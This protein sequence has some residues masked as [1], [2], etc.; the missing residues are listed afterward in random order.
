MF[1]KRLE[2]Q[3]FKSFPEKVK[4][5]FKEGVTAVVGPN[6]SG[7]SNISDAIRWVLGEQSAKSLRGDK[8]ED[9]IFTGTKNRKPLGFSEV[10]IT[11]DNLDKKLNLEF[12]EITVTRKVYRSGESGYY[13]NGAACRLKDIHELFMDTGIGKEGYSI[14]GQGKIDAILSNKSEDRRLLFEEAAGIIKFKNRRL[15]TENKLQEVKQN[16]IRTNDIIAELERQIKPLELQNEKAKEY[17]VLAKELKLIIIN[18]F[19]YEYKNSEI[20]IEEIDN[21]IKILIESIER[22]EDDK[23]KLEIN[24]ENFKQ[25]LIQNE[26]AIQCLNEDISKYKV[27]LKQK[28]T[29][30]EMYSKDIQF[31]KNDIERIK[32]DNLNFENTLK[33]KQQEINLIHTYIDGKTIEYNLK[34]KNLDELLSKFEQLKIKNNKNE[35]TIKS[36]NN[37]IIQK[38]LLS[39]ELSKKISI[40]ES[41]KKQYEERKKQ[42]FDE[43]NILNSKLNEKNI[44]KEVLQ[45]IIKQIDEKENTFKNNIDQNNILIKKIDQN[46]IKIKN[47]FSYNDKIFTESKQKLKIFQE[48]EKDY[49]GYF[50]SVKSILKE[51]ENNPKF[52]GIYGAIGELIT[53]PK[54]YE[55]AIEIALGNSIQN[56]ITKTEEDAKM[57][58]NYLKEYKKGRATFLPISSIKPKNLDNFNNFNNDTSVIGIASTLIEYDE[59]FYNIISS[60][61]GKVVIIDNINNA[62]YFSKKYNYSY[63]VVTLDGELINVGGALTGGSIFKKTGGIFSRNRE[64]SD[65]NQN[66]LILENELKKLK[67]N[68]LENESKKAKII[69]NIEN[70]NENIKA[71][72]EEKTSIKAEIVQNENYIIETLEKIKNLEKEDENLNQ[73]INFKEDESL[74]PKL[75]K[76]NNEINQCK[77][78]LLNFENELEKGKTDKDFQF[79]EINN[80]KI[81][82]N[83]IKNDIENKTKDINRIKDEINISKEMQLNFKEE[84]SKK[85]TD[86]NNIIIKIEE[87]NKEILN[88]KK[89]YENITKLYEEKYAEKANITKLVENFS[90]D[91][92]DI[93]RKIGDVNNQMTKA[94]AK[95]ENIE[96]KIERFVNNIWEEYEITYAD[97]CNDFENLEISYDELK[98]K[99]KDL[100]N[101][102]TS[103][104][105]INVSAIEEYK[106][107]KERYN[108]NI[109][110]KEDILKADNDLKKIIY[111]LTQEMEMQFKKQFSL[112]N[113][114]FKEVFSTIF[115]GG[116]A[117]LTLTD[118]ENI[119]NSGIEIVAQPPG[120]NLQ[121]LTLLSGGE[122]TLTAI[123]LLFGILKMKPSPFCILD[124]TEAALDDANVTRYANFLKKFSKDNQF[125]LITHKTGTM[126]IADIL[127]GVTMEEQGVSKVISVELKDA[128]DYNKNK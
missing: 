67:T 34:Q 13:I 33:N 73:I 74:L 20:E 9:I 41:S 16:L 92:L 51:K 116:T 98:I 64:I 52:S 60:L 114:N 65:I 94:L 2:I 26:N 23:K 31:I 123:S 1:L 63:K 49:E 46:L 120:K 122:R 50:N 17:L 105:T 125:I 27:N 77:T 7:K 55:I 115:G 78:Q 70:E 96:D 57:A 47:E 29:S 127:Y 81:S 108:L 109:S 19:K 83:S 18:I 86:K 69:S 76:I 101:K 87:V 79:N 44:R 39:S 113:K 37:D 35:E 38:M 59:K 100:K 95:K 12:D 75:N 66:I 126:E 24:Q 28:E 119:L 58:I 45:K 80:L 53:V 97:A 61:L 36:L 118:E 14:I 4:L 10:S 3:G 5:N 21:Y 68:I 25:Q 32:K 30:I 72:F 93:T 85:E 110:Q 71:I 128:K 43:K 6:G 15:Q 104:G 103:L 89:E 107:I 48:L 8:M 62:I 112:I 54:K 84:I 40:D 111:T 124:E 82:I 106:L 22:L 56:I 99:E 91:M 117:K 88:L 121:S 42:I 11:L 102:I 90:S